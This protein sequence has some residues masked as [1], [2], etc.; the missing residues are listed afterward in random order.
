[1]VR[2][3]L[4]LS[5]FVKLLWLLP[6][7]FSTTLSAQRSVVTV[8]I[9]NGKVVSKKQDSTNYST[10]YIHPVGNQRTHEINAI[11]LMTSSTWSTCG[12][13]NGSLIA[14]ASGGT[15]PY[16][17]A[18]SN[19]WIFQTGNFPFLLPGN[20]TLTVTDA[21]GQVAT[22]SVT[23]N[24]TFLPPSYL[25]ATWHPA[26]G[27]ATQDASITLFA[28]GG[29]PPYQYSIDDVNYQSSNTFSNLY[30]GFYT[31]FVK[32]ANGC[33]LLIDA[34]VVNYLMSPTCNASVGFTYTDRVCG[35]DGS[36]HGHAFGV[37]GPFLYSLDG[38][39]YQSTMDFTNLS[40]GIY[41]LHVRF[42][43]G[44]EAIFTFVLRPSCAIRIDYITVDA[45][46]QQNDGTLTATASLGTAPYTYTLDGVNFQ[47]SNVF[48]G[49]SPGSYFITVKDANGFTSSAFAELY[50]RCP[51]VTLTATSEGCAH[52]DGTIT[53]TATKGTAPY[54]YSID[55]I[56]FQS[57]NIFTGL[58]AGNY[59]IT[60]KDALGFTST[61]NITINYNCFGVTATHTN[62]VCGN[63][64]ATII[65]TAIGGTGPYQYSLNGINFQ[66]GNIFNGL[67]AGTYT[68]TV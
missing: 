37:G 31:F 20:Y 12:I 32:D 50:D 53:A 46:C 1:M 27:C 48:T 60:L 4:N 58:P 41:Y 40:A 9:L 52:N 63:M 26:S 6:L 21:V 38:T 28:T 14:V 47:A 45:A 19:G 49:L 15:P 44:T 54:Q 59:T 10:I 35:N 67:G 42:A 56:N 23:I 68:V 30:P 18:L 62:V 34:F 29:A 25:P 2:R 33:K 3:K 5:F 11:T 51:S 65:T 24:N 8:N 36:I 61:A 22:A 17:Y 39:N 57:S 66:P 55:G 64:N 13:N 43:D 7:I 16:T